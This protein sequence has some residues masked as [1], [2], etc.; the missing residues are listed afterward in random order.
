MAQ[1]QTVSKLMEMRMSVMARTYRDI[2]TT[3]G[4]TEMTFDEKVATMVDAE[5]D[6]RRTNKRAR[7]LRQANFC[8]PDANV[9]DAFYFP[10]RELDKP[11]ILEMSNCERIKEGRNIVITG[12]S[13][14]G[15]SWLSNALGVA[16]C[17]AFYS[18]RYTRLPDTLEELAIQKDEAWLKAKKR[19]MK[20]DLLILD[21]WLLTPIK[22]EEA[23]EVLEIVEGRSHSGSLIL[24]SLFAPA[25]WH[26]ALGGGAVADAVIDRIVYNSYV[27]HIKGEESMRKRTSTLQSNS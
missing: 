6:S 18:V 26:S 12:A 16:A 4:F 25:G 8:M 21:E 15:K 27:I 11:Q 23:R 17:N 22:A 7:L 14:A 10:D 24:C 2:G 1:E 5:W 13:G 20:C 9:A 3:P 19:Y